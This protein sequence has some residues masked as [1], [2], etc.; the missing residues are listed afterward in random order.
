M[1]DESCK[2][3][4]MCQLCSRTFKFSARLVT[5]GST[6]GWPRSQQGS[7][8]VSACSP[9]DVS[10]A[11]GAMT[12]RTLPHSTGKSTHSRVKGTDTW[13][14]KRACACACIEDR[15]SVWSLLTNH[16]YTKKKRTLANLYT[17]NLTNQPLSASHKRLV[18]AP[19]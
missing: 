4:K 5:A 10:L 2:H 19:R 17:R 3:N 7:T 11:P 18:S 6:Q 16:G 15:I 14:H 12:V 8:L 9:S 13:R 1:H